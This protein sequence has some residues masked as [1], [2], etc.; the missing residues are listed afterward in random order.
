MRPK[1]AV[2]VAVALLVLILAA[3]QAPQAAGAVLVTFSV[4]AFAWAVVG[5][6]KPQW[7]RL[8]NRL[9]SV[10]VWAVSFGLLIAGVQVSA[11]PTE[12]AR[13]SDRLPSSAPARSQPDLPSVHVEAEPI[14]DPILEVATVGDLRQERICPEPDTYIVQVL[15]D[16]D[17]MA[18]AILSRDDGGGADGLG[19]VVDAVMRF[20]GQSRFA[21]S[22][23]VELAAECYLLS[24]QTGIA[25]QTATARLR[26]AAA[27]E[28]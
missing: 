21:S 8:P 28:R 10:W 13:S 17:N 9:A 4:V 14:P 19:T 12:V 7:A 25:G 27:H 6:L 16:G 18:T 20:A 1:I 23:P 3:N 11:P 15:A 22:A 2:A 5:L 26:P 24:A